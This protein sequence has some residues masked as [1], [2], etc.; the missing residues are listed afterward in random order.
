MTNT[1]KLAAVFRFD[2]NT[3]HTTHQTQITTDKI[4]TYMYTD[5]LSQ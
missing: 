3:K 2:M 5:N 4:Y 1:M